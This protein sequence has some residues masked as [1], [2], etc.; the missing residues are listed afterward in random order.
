MF[1]TTAVAQWDGKARLPT[2]E[3]LLK[4]KVGWYFFFFKG[5]VLRPL[6][7]CRL[8]ASHMQGAHAT[9]HSSTQSLR[10]GLTAT[11][12]PYAYSA[13]FQLRAG[14]GTEAAS[15]VKQMGSA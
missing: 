11:D 4:V 3:L 13:R 2:Q 10:R 1:A 8:Q 6:G 7:G 15:R 12:S 9:H 5:E 14:D